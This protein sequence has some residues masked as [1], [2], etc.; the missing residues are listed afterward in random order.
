[1]PQEIDFDKLL[2]FT[3]K[4]TQAREAV[5]NYDYVLYGGALGGGSGPVHR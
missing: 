4:Q 2:N 1:M 3:D 5:K